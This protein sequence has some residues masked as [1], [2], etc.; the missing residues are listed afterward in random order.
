M[1]VATTSD[2]RV[3]FLSVSAEMGGSEV[4]RQLGNLMGGLP[5]TVVV[6]SNGSILQ[7]KMGRVTKDELERW[8]GLR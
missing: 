6:G 1:T 7:R 8:R 2:L 4:S 5:F 3:T